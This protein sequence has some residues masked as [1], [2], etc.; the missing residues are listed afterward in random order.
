MCLE[1]I[2]ECLGEAIVVRQL[3]RGEIDVS[4]ADENLALKILVAFV[5]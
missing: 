4:N 3:P 1:Q 5:P 2:V